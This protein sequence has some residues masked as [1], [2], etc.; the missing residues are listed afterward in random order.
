MDELELEANWL[1]VKTAKH[2]F[3]SEPVESLFDVYKE[4]NKLPAA[5]DSIIKLTKIVFTLP[6]STASNERMFSVLKRVK[7]YIRSTCGDER[8]SSLMLMASEKEFIKNI[9][10]DKLIDNNFGRM[11]PRRY[12]VLQS[13]K[14]AET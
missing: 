5:F 3:E 1:Q 10:Y 7:T 6:V 2:L 8:L 13:S 4:L 9:D 14:S 11:R 12:P